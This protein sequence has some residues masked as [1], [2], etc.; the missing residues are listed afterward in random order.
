MPLS[1]GNRKLGKHVYNYNL[2][3]HTCR[4]KTASCEKFCY[5]RKGAF[6]Y[7]QVVAFMKRNYNETLEDDFI[8]RMVGQIVFLRIKWIRIHACGDFYSQGYA[9]KWME[10]ARRSPNSHF[11]AYTRDYEIDFSTRPDNFV[12]YFSKDGSTTELNESIHMFAS[13][14]PMEKGIT[15]MSDSKHGHVCDSKCKTCKACWS[16]KVQIAFPLR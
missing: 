11:L 8:D 12:M 16:G 10:I 1:N 2:P 9:D 4:H 13:T 6:V 15:H 5:A 3:R 14:F 7:P